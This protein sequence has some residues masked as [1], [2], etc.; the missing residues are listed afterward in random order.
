[1]KIIET[2]SDWKSRRLK[3][4]LGRRAMLFQHCWKLTCLSMSVGSCSASI[5][6]RATWIRTRRRK[7]SGPLSEVEEGP[8]Y[9]MPVKVVRLAWFEP[10]GRLTSSYF[11]RF[12]NFMK[13]GLRA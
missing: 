4:M 8:D 9:D 6:T 10:T 2:R 3:L 5:I 1:M 12:H 7:Y 13:M 11:I